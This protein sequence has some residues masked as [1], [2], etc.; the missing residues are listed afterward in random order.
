[1]KRLDASRLEM[2]RVTFV[3]RRGILPVG[4]NKTRKSPPKPGVA[5][6]YKT[7]DRRQLSP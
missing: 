7:I 1:M 4:Q 2:F 5:M 3:P 6:R